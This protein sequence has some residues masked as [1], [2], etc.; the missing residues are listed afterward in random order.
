MFSFRE[1]FYKY[2][3]WDNDNY[4]KLFIEPISIPIAWLL[5]SFTRLSANQITLFGCFL[6]IGGALIGTVKAPF[7]LYGFLGFY[8]VDFVDGKVAR[9]LKASSPLGKRLDVLVDRAVFSA[10]SLG[11][12]H[13]HL[14]SMENAAPL[15]LFL[16]VV[17][18][19]YTD[20]IEYSGL[21]YRGALGKLPPKGTIAGEWTNA[22]IARHLISPERWLP[23]RLS[24]PIF[25]IV[26]FLFTGDFTKSYFV[27]TIAALVRPLYFLVKRRF[28]HEL[29]E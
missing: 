4:I 24:S 9:A 23:S 19:F 16:F 5:L 14:G 18:Y 2:T 29:R 22:V 28:I 1:L 7:I 6:G 3:N 10:C 8:Y 11:L 13:F 20:I 25:L 27:A 12:M 15:T 21:V 26:T 17:V